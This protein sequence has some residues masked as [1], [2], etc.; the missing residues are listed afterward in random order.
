MRVAK[1]FKNGQSQAVRL[2]KEFRLE[3][4]QVFVNRI[5]NV[6]VLIPEKNSWEPLLSS[7][8]KFS[9]DFMCQRNQPPAQQKRERL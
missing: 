9:L 5:G 7:L 4:K 3:G 1:I 2:P 8:G 6:I